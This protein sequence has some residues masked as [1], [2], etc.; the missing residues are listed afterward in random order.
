MIAG[1]PYDSPEALAMTGAITS[2][3]TS[4]SYAMSALLAKEIGTFK[5]YEINKNDM[6]RVIRNH[7][8][9]A[10]NAEQY[11]NLSIKPQGI[12]A[13]NCPEYLLDAAKKSWDNTLELGTQ[14]GFRNAQVS[15]IAPTGTIALVMDCD[16]TGIEPDFAIVKYK[17]LAGGGYFKIVNQSVKIA[18][19]KLGY[20][21]REIEDIE[22]YS[23]GNPTLLNCPAINR[24]SLKTKGFTDEIIDEIEKQLSTVF[25]IK[26]AFNK[27]TVGEEF[28]MKIGFAKTDLEN[29]NLDILSQ[30]G[31]SEKEI[32]KAND[33]ICGTMMLEGAPHLQ[34]VHLPIFDC[35]NKCGKNGKRFIPYMAHLRIMAAAQPFITGAISKTVNMPA[36]ATVDEISNVHITAW[37]MMLKAI[38]IYRDGSKLSQPLCSSILSDLDEVVTLGDEILLDETL[39][40]REV[41]EMQ[42]HR[43][44]RKKLPKRRKGITREATVGG[45][46]I[47]LRTGEYEDGTLGE[48]FLDMYKDGAAFRGMLNSFAILVSKA[49]QYGVPLEE[50][51]DTF[52]FTK[53]EPQGIVQGH[54][55]VKFASSVLDYVFRSLGYDYLDRTDFV[56]KKDNDKTTNGSKN[57]A[58]FLVNGS[59]SQVQKTSTVSLEQT[60]STVDK[61]L[62]DIGI[63]DDETAA[64]TIELP[65]TNGNSS[66]NFGAMHASNPVLTLQKKLLG[67]TGEQCTQCSSMRV[68]RNGSCLLCEDCGTTSG[69]S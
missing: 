45:Q 38:T 24:Q 58:N 11:E 28:L 67:Y 66:S 47:F 15:V 31:F 13:E 5:H 52:T 4:E 44:V 23:I 61:L 64:D 26:F 29:P 60:I 63:T 41:H 56:H 1:I 40:P 37:K 59:D 39:G 35:A 7:R 55:A 43:L 33:F 22:K 25:D 53:F 36:N 68:K 20:T 3:L 10:Y 50:L 69:C 46:K 54:E 21:H 57:P 51:V 18:L 32:E 42:V 12:N 27:H 19:K 16:T 14:Y 17:K 49:L 34:S 30:L 9:A 6:L 2:L 48:I 8:N 65:F 62:H